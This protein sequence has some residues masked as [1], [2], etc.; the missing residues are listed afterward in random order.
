MSFSPHTNDDLPFHVGD[1]LTDF[2]AVDVTVQRVA[3]G[4]FGAV[5]LGPNGRLGGKWSALKTLRR[6]F[7]DNPEVR[8]LFVRES[9]T[10]VGL[11]SH[12]NVLTAQ[13]V[14]EINSL[15]VLVLDYAAHGSLRNV[16]DGGWLRWQAALTLTQQILAGLAYL[17][18]PD[19]ALLRPRPI[20]HRDL[21]PENVL[22]DDD[23]LALITDFGLAKVVAEGL[24][25][26]L[27]T[28]LDEEESSNAAG[29]TQIYRTAR[30]KALG[31]PAYMAPEQWEDAAS[32][33]P[34]ADIYA[35]GLLMVELLTGQHPLFPLNERHSHQEWRQAHQQAALRLPA[36]ETLTPGAIRAAWPS[37]L[38]A[39]VW[40]ILQACLAREPAA[41]P[42][43]QQALGALR[44]LGA[45]LGEQPYDPPEV[46]PHTREH[47]R[48]FWHGW[49]V[50]YLDFGRY[51]E[52]LTR[53]DRALAL[54]AHNPDVLLSRGN[55]LLRLRR[56]AE[57]EDAY[58]R[59]L[60]VFPP[61]G[62]EQRGIVWTM[63]GMLCQDQGQYAK[64]E[65][66]YAQAVALSPGN[67]VAWHNCANN[68]R[69][70][71]Q[72]EAQAGRITQARDACAQGA[73]WAN[74]ALRL[75]Q[76]DPTTQQVLTALQGLAAK[77]G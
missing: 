58:Q 4:G 77:L 61:E 11:W 20:V 29:T 66:A 1:R 25:A 41:R 68:A 19:P 54:A 12:A 5:A 7:L 35:A 48:N 44:Q 9:L 75:N 42:T 64:A 76:H 2:S 52:A 71:A 60:A 23:G 59:A 40:E 62:A 31:T 49:A 72:T 10:W 50:A 13:F 74:E 51:E 43:A 69:L 15:P 38:A 24:G 45:R 30:G 18:T 63:L 14:T 8:E 16:L 22:L 33:G 47:E 39:G 6:R 26:D 21:K 37:E 17:H 32:A 70:L 56:F 3:S 65:Q 57:A 46:Y 34:P 73:T 53:N 67:A 55:I 36:L 27:D 28:V